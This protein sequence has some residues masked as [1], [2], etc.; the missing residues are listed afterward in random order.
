MNLSLNEAETKALQGALENYLSNL[1][2][3]I[4]KTEKHE[5]KEALQR[6]KEILAHIRQ[7]LH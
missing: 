6:E 7:R 1:R 3:E 4:T 5:W 2:E